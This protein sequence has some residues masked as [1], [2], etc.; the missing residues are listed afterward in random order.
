MEL[1]LN[2]QNFSR[3]VN[4][5]LAHLVKLMKAGKAYAMRAAISGD[6]LYALY[7][8]S[9]PEGSNPIFRTRTEHD[10]SCCKSFIRTLGN[11]VF[12][13]EDNSHAS[14]W[15]G[16]VNN[17]PEYSIVSAALSNAVTTSPLDKPFLHYEAAIGKA[18]T[19]EHLLDGKAHEWHHFNAHIPADLVAQKG[20]IATTLGTASSTYA[21]F[22][23]AL[24]EFKTE[25]ISTLIQLA[26]ENAVYRLSDHVGILQQFLTVL[27]SIQKTAKAHEIAWRIASR[28]SSS[29]TN[30]R[31]TAL[32]TLLQDMATGVDLESAINKYEAMVAGSNYKRPKALVTQKQIEQ[33]SQ[34]LRDLGLEPALARRHAHYHD[35]DIANVI[36]SDRT[37]PTRLLANSPLDLL[38]PTK[39]KV[40]ATPNARIPEMSFDTFCESV[41]PTAEKVELFFASAHTPRL[42]SLLTAENPTAPSLFKW[43]NPFSWSYRGDVADSIKD[44]VKA[45]GGSVTGQVR[46]SLAWFNTDDLDLHLVHPDGKSCYFGNKSHNGGVLDVDKNAFGTLVSDPVENIAFASTNKMANGTYKVIVNQFRVRDADNEGFAVEIEIQ[47]Q[48][49]SLSYPQKVASNADIHVADIVFDKK[50]NTFTVKPK[51][52]STL[53]SRS[54]WNCPTEQ[55]VRCSAI[56][57]S[58]NAWEPQAGSSLKHTFFFLADCASDEPLRGFYNEFLRDELQP[59]RKT[60]ELLGS[61]TMVP[62]TEPNLQL[63]GLGFSDSLPASLRVRVTSAT[64]QREYLIKFAN[65]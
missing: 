28:G 49:W 43:N 10:C 29:L 11:I 60:L 34:T 32:G 42:M 41:L 44:R 64:L 36:F 5:N 27:T 8:S 18:I 58:P 23:R 48:L 1:P 46:I 39:N 62:P 6:D 57:R 63:S 38:S 61:K 47:G 35:L 9:F 50:A 25:D 24:T 54:V 40:S 45:A 30:L 51:I 19:I 7:L 20:S 12:V 3:H 21:V 52:N 65:A 53:A 26:K 17:E 22:L 31:N 59:H 56:V 37:A 55:W 15:D 16:L 2:F 33:A 14:I 4:A 13:L